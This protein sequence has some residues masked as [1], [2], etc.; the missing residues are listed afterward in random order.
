MGLR[1]VSHPDILRRNAAALGERTAFLFEGRRV[2]HRD[3]LRRVERLAAG[4]AQAG[5][6]AGGR[7]AVSAR[8]G[9][10]FV[11]LYGATAWLGA[12]MLPVNW[13]LAPDE[14]AY[15]LAD[16]AP[17]LVIADA[18][19]QPGI[20]ALAASLPS[21]TGYYGLGGT[22]APFRPFA[23]LA[24][25]AAAPP[26][27]ASGGD[28]GAVIIHTAAVDGHPRGALLSHANLIAAAGQM[29]A[30]WQL[31]ERDAGLI[32]LPL[33]HIA[34]LGLLL[35]V[36][37]AGG[38]S[39]IQPKFEP[40]SA[41]RLVAEEQAT[42]FVEFA[43]ML[44]ALLDKAAALGASLASLRAV[45][46]L[47]TPE[48]IARFEA[49]CPAARFWA[50]YG[51]SETSGFVTLSP[52]R[53][54]P[55]SAGRV[56]GLNLVA[57]VDE[58]DRDLPAGEIGEI[59]VRGP[60]VFQGYWRREADTAVAWRNDWHHTGDL[61]R[62]DADGYLWYAGRSPAKE[63]IKPGG[64]NVYPAEVERTI[65][66]HEAIAEVAVIGVPD[67]QWGEAIKAVCVCRPGMS[68]TAAALIDFV[69]SRIARF[70]KPKQVVFVAALPRTASGVIDRAK[71]KEEHGRA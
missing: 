20:A 7:I 17:R 14:I 37:L 64:E 44:G 48:T 63:L 52:W 65:R 28:D 11:D 18:E 12:I 24:D 9:L 4:L 26:V 49:A 61:G 62:F 54:R 19:D 3:H 39:L 69:G 2:S 5:I 58:L 55:G 51:Q 66:E 40:E 56:T 36:Q 43:P 15:V 45:A 53:A 35:A 34:G 27:A 47:D 30:S 16:G 38:A 10:E 29:V 46:G 41:A 57:V 8:N 68:L 33:F 22:L 25:C 21:V 60:L 70:K 31:D 13:R 42:V 23:E 32:A 50:G 1:N 71:V 67:A 59:V 6:R